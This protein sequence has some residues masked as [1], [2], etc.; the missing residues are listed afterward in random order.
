MPSNYIYDFTAFV[1]LLPSELGGR[2]NNVY[3][4]FRPSFTFGTTRHYSGELFFSKK[5]PIK[6]GENAMMTVKLLPAVTIPKNLSVNDTF[7]IYEG[8]RVIGH[9][10]IKSEIV[11]REIETIDINS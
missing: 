1:T 4:G 7:K 10:L 3:S 11:K 2:K 6:P 8:N 5:T 9:G